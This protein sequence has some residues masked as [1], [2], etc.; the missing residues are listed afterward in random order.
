MI[1]H[2]EIY[3]LPPEQ[4]ERV[5][6]LIDRGQELFDMPN[7]LSTVEAWEKQFADAEA[8]GVPHYAA[9]ARFGQLSI[10]LSG[11]L[12]HE[13]LAAYARLM[14]YVERY[15]EY[16]NASN[17]QRFLGSLSSV[18]SLLVED[19]S[20]SREQ[21]ERVIDLVE[22]QTRARGLNLGEI[23]LARA[24]LASDLG[25]VA[26]M[27]EWRHRW[28]A[29]GH[30]DWSEDNYDT[31]QRD[32]ALL[33]PH[34][35]AEAVALLERRFAA[36][37]VPPGPLDPED[38]DLDVLASLRVRLA[39]LFARI[40]RRDIAATIG[41]DIADQF[42]AEWLTRNTLLEEALI[43]L[44]H[45]PEDAYVVADY[46]LSQIE[47]G[48]S[49]WQLVASLARNRI[50][51]DAQGE[52]GRLLQQ[53]AFENAEA[54]DERGGTDWHTLELQQFWFAGL[55]EAP[56]PT[57]IDDPEIWGHIE[58]RAERILRAGWLQRQQRGVDPTN[59]PIGIGG[60][61]QEL[62]MSAVGLFETESAE[63]ADALEA[64]IYARA[65]ELR[66]PSAAYSARLMRG[67]RAVEDGDYPGF[68][69][70]FAEA[71]QEQL[72]HHDM[73][74]PG[75]RA[76]ALGMF[77][78]AIQAGVL[79]PTVSIQM[80]QNIIQTQEQLRSIA[81]MPLAPLLLAHAELAAHFGDGETLFRLV[82]QITQQS[83]A[84]Q[85]DL[86]RHRIALST[87]RLVW[88][89]SSE[90]ARGLAE[91]VL[92]E[93]NDPEHQRNAFTWV[94]WFDLRNGG[95][96]R[97]DT[98]IEMFE[99]VDGDVN[100]FG[101]VPNSVLLDVVATRRDALPW[102]LEAVLE[103]SDAGVAPELDTWAVAGK[104]LLERNPEDARGLELRDLAL[105]I[106]GELDARNGNTF[107]STIL[108][109]RFGFSP[110]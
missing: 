5:R 62:T 73:I 68:L 81:E 19:A 104:L 31:T 107:Q 78:V 97:A 96:A 75:I 72:Q 24:E 33:A 89:Y 35:P 102:V 47:F 58:E 13:S 56:R 43:A 36:W 50:L 28:H 57:I 51:A 110:R 61:Y 44:E 46:A 100:E 16:I 101:S 52:E 18:V 6:A 11:G 94:G 90:Y 53:I 99:S 84:E 45:R 71:Q 74:E 103:N 79:E 34:D 77:P 37:G 25:D 95:D 83:E 64:S 91:W 105:R 108:Q 80:L 8:E 87:V 4:T 9:S 12:A 3:D 69:R 26:A 86:D 63:E 17:I 55:P 40:G 76:A 106:V 93:T 67:A 7:D 82:S 42:S 2:D 27:H 92:N 49:D 109:Q 59:P 10:Y 20:I 70:A 15:G 54:L 22:R 23:Y 41:N 32:V 85:D 21:M 65:Q 48:H 1:R 29:A 60:R 88:P 39:F 14:Q 98:V 66:Y 30:E 38:P